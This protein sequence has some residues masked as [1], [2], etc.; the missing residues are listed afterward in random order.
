MIWWRWIWCRSSA[1]LVLSGRCPR[2][3]PTRRRPAYRD[4]TA[5]K[6]RLALFLDYDAGDDRGLYQNRDRGGGCRPGQRAR[7]ETR[8]ELRDAGTEIERTLAAR[9]TR[10]L[11]VDRCEQLFHGPRRRRTQ[12]LV[13]VDRLG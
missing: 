7:R 2:S 4:R 13:E 5:P 8:Q 10:L 9:R 1:R 11:S 6:S 3:S 12:C